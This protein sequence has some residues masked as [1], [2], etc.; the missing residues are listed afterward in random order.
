MADAV[1]QKDPETGRFV[2]GNI[3]GGRQKGS[4]NKLT[5]QFWQDL[6]GAWEQGGQAAIIET[7]TEH[8]KDFVKIVASLMPK[9]FVVKEQSEI[10]E[11]TDE[12]LIATLAAVKSLLAKSAGEQTGKGN[13]EANGKDLSSPV[14]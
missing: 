5:E 4:R 14:H 12:Q 10:D 1:P 11:M 13:A 3:G 6:H 9:E 2:S 8:P 7:M